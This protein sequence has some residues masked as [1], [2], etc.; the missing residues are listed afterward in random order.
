M[1]VVAADAVV[2]GGCAVVRT[3]RRQGVWG[4]NVGRGKEGKWALVAVGGAAVTAARWVWR[5]RRG[6]VVVEG[7]RRRKRGKGEGGGVAVGS[8]W[9]SGVDGGQ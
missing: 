7:R 3:V 5:S 1:V 6:A 4:G 2:D 8:G 9:S